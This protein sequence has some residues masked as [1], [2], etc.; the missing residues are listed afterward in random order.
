MHNYN[1]LQPI[2][3][4][5]L[6]KEY[7][8]YFVLSENGK[9]S[10][11]LTAGQFMRCL[12][13][14]QVWVVSPDTATHARIYSVV[15]CLLL[16]KSNGIIHKYKLST[17]SVILL[18]LLFLAHLIHSDES[19]VLLLSKVRE[20]GHFVCYVGGRMLGRPNS[21]SL[22]G[23]GDLGLP[24]SASQALGLPHFLM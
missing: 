20:I 12:G 5:K 21:H 13:H 10:G 3:F 24:N 6:F 7:L 17:V 16:G 22:I 8:H 1:V 2:A 15:S 18:P 23:S 14:T 9:M 4:E 11:R 19:D